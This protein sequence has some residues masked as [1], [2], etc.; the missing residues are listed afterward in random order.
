M[1]MRLLARL[2][3]SWRGLVRRAGVEAEMNEEFH[4]HL[5]MRAAELTRRGLAPAE[6]AR[7]A[8]IEF[9]HIDSHKEDARASRGLRL[10]DEIGFSWLDVK[11]G[12]RMLAK[13]PWLSL[14]SVIGMAVAIAIGAG[15]FSAIHAITD[16]TLP[17]PAGDR[18]VS[19]ENDTDAPGDTNRRALFDFSVWR[20]ELGTVR[21]VS[22]FRTEAR[23]LIVPGRTPEVVSVASMSPSGFR[24]AGAAPLLGRTL[25][26]HRRPPGSAGEAA[27]V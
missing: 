9:G 15:T 14:V 13:H 16:T 23:N 27:T 11:L 22:A 18:L 1:N 26:T 2:R 4:H 5:E 21:D 25:A 17:L 24:A 12:V 3:S 6:A 7:Q 20:E 8:R 19:I 10:F